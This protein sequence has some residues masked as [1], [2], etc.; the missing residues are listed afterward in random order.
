MATRYDNLPT[1]EIL[2]LELDIRIEHRQVRHLIADRFKAEALEK[3]ELGKAYKIAKGRFEGRYMI[4]AFIVVGGAQFDPSPKALFPIAE[5]RLS[6][7]HGLR[8]WTTK[9]QQVRIENLD[10]STAID[11]ALFKRPKSVKEGGENG[12]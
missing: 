3:Y 2:Q 10:L 4:L 5:G 1:D 11:P 12:S 9:T 7:T 8:P 6:I